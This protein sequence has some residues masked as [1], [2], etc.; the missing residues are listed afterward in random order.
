MPDVEIHL[1]CISREFSSTGKNLLPML[2][3]S[4]GDR[5]WIDFTIL[6]SALQVAWLTRKAIAGIC[7]HTHVQVESAPTP[8]FGQ[9]SVV[10]SPIIVHK[11]GS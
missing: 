1:S 4:G 5:R 6:H 2:I 10:G 3:L 11:L 9:S 7:P 8:L